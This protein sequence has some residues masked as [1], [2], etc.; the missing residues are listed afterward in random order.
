LGALRKLAATQAIKRDDW[1]DAQPGRML[2]EQHAD[3]ASALNLRPQGLYFGGVSESILYPI[4]V[5]QLWRWTGDRDL[6]QPFVEPALKALHWMDAWLRD[7]SGFY[8]YRTYSEQ[9]LKNQGWKDSG[10]AIVHTDGSQVEDP[11]GTCE[12]QGFA[13]TAKLHFADLLWWL[14]RKDEARG[15]YEDSRDL[16]RRFNQTFWLEEEGFLAMALDRHDQP[17]RSVGSD[18]GRCLVAGVVDA[19]LAPRVANRM[20]QPDLFSGWGVRTLSAAHP[21]YNPFAYHRGTIWPVEN[22]SFVLGFARYGLREQMWRL[23]RAFF[24]TAALFDHDRLPEVL[25]GHPRDA[26]HPFPGLYYRAGWPQAW[27]ATAA[28]VV[29]EALLGLVPYAPLQT[30]LLDPW[31]PDWLPELTLEGL[32]VGAA[33]VSLHFFRTDRGETGY[34]VAALEGPLHVKRQP[35]PWSLLEGPAEAVKAAVEALLSP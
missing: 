23:A 1:R 17:V 18:P 5:G 6:V 33:T 32:R 25:G 3:P 29:I 27:S 2:H 28:F 19:E 12:M 10:D 8:K 21:A 24:E 11:L 13:Y 20:L 34:E 22:G 15:F 31:L 26:T 30:L 16:K 7:A 9:G 14:D 4:L 35:A